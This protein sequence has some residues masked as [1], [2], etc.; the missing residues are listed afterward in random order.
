MLFF[1]VGQP[2]L[3]GIYCIFIGFLSRPSTQFHGSLFFFLVIYVAV[4]SR[5]D[6]FRAFFN[7]KLRMVSSFL[8]VVSSRNIERTMFCSGSLIF[9]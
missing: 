4:F 7:R 6:L 1:L 9:S 8:A 5:L 2:Y 3:C